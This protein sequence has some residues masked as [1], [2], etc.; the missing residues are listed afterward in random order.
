MG[1]ME[2]TTEAYVLGMAKIWVEKL[3]DNFQGVKG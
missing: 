2:A 3:E 1:C